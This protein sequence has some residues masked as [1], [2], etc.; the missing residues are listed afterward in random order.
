MNLTLGCYFR[1]NGPVGWGNQF[2]GTPAWSSF[3]SVKCRT[4]WPKPSAI[5][6]LC[7]TFGLYKQFS[8]TNVPIVAG[9]HLGSNHFKFLKS[10]CQF[11]WTPS[12]SLYLT[13]EVSIPIA[14]HGSYVVT[15]LNWP[16]VFKCVCHGL[17][18]Q[19]NIKRR[20]DEQSNFR[21]V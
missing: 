15:L 17:Y 11:L 6:S 5:Y 19:T 4:W 7:L 18:L 3:M 14:G 16:P 1:G 20:H 10:T 9:T 13:P 21:H 8:W 12:S 2:T